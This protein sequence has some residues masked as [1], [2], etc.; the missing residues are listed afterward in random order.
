MLSWAAARVS[1]CR[2]R[3]G[4]RWVAKGLIVERGLIWCDGEPMTGRQDGWAR[5]GCCATRME[6]HETGEEDSADGRFQRAILP[7]SS[8]RA[9]RKTDVAPLIASAAMRAA[10]SRS[11]HAVPVPKTPSAAKAD[12]DIADRVVARADPHRAHVGVAAIRSLET[13]ATQ[14][15]GWPPAPA[16]ADNAHRDGFR[17][18]AGLAKPP[19]LRGP[20]R[21]IP[22]AAMQAAFTTAAFERTKCIAIDSTASDKP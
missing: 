3:G 16:T 22:N 21:E 14:R 7:R 9:C 15:R 12:G 4:S 2:P 1:A 18:R 8:I 6:T 19:T 10:T 13:A 11:G 20:G 17:W 5:I